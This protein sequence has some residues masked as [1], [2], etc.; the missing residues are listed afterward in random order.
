MGSLQENDFTRAPNCHG[1]PALTSRQG[2]SAKDFD[3]WLAAFLEDAI[4]RAEDSRTIQD[5]LH[6][7]AAQALRQ[8]GVSEADLARLSTNTRLMA[9]GQAIQD[10]M[11][12]FV[13][14]GLDSLV[15]QVRERTGPAAPSRVRVFVSSP[16]DLKRERILVADVCRDLGTIL[17]RDIRALLWEGAGPKHPESSPFTAE[18]TGQGPQAVIDDQIRDALGGYDIYVGMM[19]LRMGTPTGEWRSGT[20]AEFR[21]ALDGFQREG[22]PRKV[23]FYTKRP[24]AAL[25]RSPE[26]ADFIRELETELGLPQRFRTSVELRALLIHDLS[27]ELRAR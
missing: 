24:T 2:R 27:A 9:R 17:E 26:A 19:W 22:R 1:S 25:E 7:P 16:G 11:V 6:W 5:E 23:L 10:P 15:Q 8:L 18:I 14:E 3:G 20:E 13:A 21:Y 12:V 4:S